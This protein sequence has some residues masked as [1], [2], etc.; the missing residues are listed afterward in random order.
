[1]KAIKAKEQSTIEFHVDILVHEAIDRDTIGL[2]WADGGV[3]PIQLEGKKISELDDTTKK[4]FFAAVVE[5]MVLANGCGTFKALVVNEC[6]VPFAEHG[7]ANFFSKLGYAALKVEPR[8]E[9][10]VCPAQSQNPS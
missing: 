9:V 1:M 7:V 6:N 2:G 10:S 4:D 5:E 8:G 3:S